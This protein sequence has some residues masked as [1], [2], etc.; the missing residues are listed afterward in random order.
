MKIGGSHNYTPAC[1]Q[2]PKHACILHFPCPLQDPPVQYILR[3]L[4]YQYCTL[5]YLKGIHRIGAC[6]TARISTIPEGLRVDKGLASKELEWN[7]LFG[8]V[9]DVLCGLWQGNAQVLVMTTM[10]DL[11]TGTPR[12]RR[13][14]RE[15]QLNSKITRA[16][17]GDEVRLPSPALRWM[18]N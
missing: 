4:L 16:V 1:V 18:L 15:N 8:T 9:D 12:L 5:C 11:Q 10:H 14:P 7:D 3:Q 17:F 6:G 13:R 2:P